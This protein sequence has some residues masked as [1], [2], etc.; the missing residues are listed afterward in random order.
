MISGTTCPTCSTV[1]LRRRVSTPS[2]PCPCRR[3][4]LRFPLLAEA[5]FLA[6]GFDDCLII[7][8]DKIESFVLF[9]FLHID[10]CMF[11]DKLRKKNY[12]TYT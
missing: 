9:F 3:L 7:M 1:R 2:R 4:R 12:S 6:E 10:I 5:L 8:H 11:F